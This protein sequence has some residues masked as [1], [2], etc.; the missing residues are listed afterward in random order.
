MIDTIPNI[1]SHFLIISFKFIFINNRNNNGNDIK[2]NLQ[3][4]GIKSNTNHNGKYQRIKIYNIQS[5]YL[6]N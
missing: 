5:Q 1:G 4:I 2:R 6:I 3:Y